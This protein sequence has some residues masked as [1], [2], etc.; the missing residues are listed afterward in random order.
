MLY[1][2]Y[3][4]FDIFVVVKKILSSNC[5]SNPLG[6]YNKNPKID[7]SDYIDLFVFGHLKENRSSILN[8]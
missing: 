8:Y 2:F 1:I 5:L 4:Y 7:T 3:W 6:L